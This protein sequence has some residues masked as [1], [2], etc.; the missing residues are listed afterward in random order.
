MSVAI[1]LSD[2]VLRRLEAAAAALHAPQTGLG[3]SDA[4]AN[5]L[6]LNQLG[7]AAGGGEVGPA[8]RQSVATASAS[9]IPCIRSPLSEPIR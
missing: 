4:L 1:E 9:Q 5:V 8:D 2:E 6:A 7:C 3:E